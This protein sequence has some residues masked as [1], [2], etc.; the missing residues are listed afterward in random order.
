MITFTL[1]LP[2]RFLNPN[3]RI[4][5]AKKARAVKAART[6]AK[7][8]LS[9][10]I[11]PGSPSPKHYVLHFYYPDKRRRD[12]DNA[13]ASCK[14]YRDGFADALGIDDHSL[15]LI[16]TTIAFDRKDPRFEIHLLP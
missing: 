11:Q 4:H 14:A 5:W 1:P 16:D 13:A 8:T 7:L 2:S 6:L 15:K 9:P 3:A 10:L 12:D